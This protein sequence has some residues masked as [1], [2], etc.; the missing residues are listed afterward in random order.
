[1]IIKK[2]Y[3][4]GMA[5]C[6]MAAVLINNEIT[7]QASQVSRQKPKQVET[8]LETEESVEAESESETESELLE[9]TQDEI[10]SFY[11]DSVFVGDSLMLGFRNYAMK[12][13]DD[14]LLSRMKFLA[15]GSLSV[16][17]SFWDTKNKNSVHPIYQGK[18]RYIWESI[19][20]MKSKRVFIMLGINDLNVYGLEKTRD[21]YAELIGKIEENNPDAEV[22]IMSMTYV[23]HG[24]EKGNL[25]NDTIREFN[26][27]L[28]E[29]AEENEWGYVSLADSLADKN[30]DLAKEFCSDGFIHQNAAAYDVW[31]SVLKDYAAQQLSRESTEEAETEEEET[32]E[33]NSTAIGTVKNGVEGLE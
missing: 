4:C 12:R 29:L 8:E 21:K 30:G 11:D 31:V 14:T 24:K 17:N 15:A 33:I 16:N 23:L 26:G 9:F 28:E 6:L 2:F 32:A 7:V 1:M 10:E 25:E 27:M 13:K 3:G 18:K 5:L 20:L 22:H 19:S